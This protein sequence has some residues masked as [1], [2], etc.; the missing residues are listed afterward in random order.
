[1][2]PVDM[3]ANLDSGATRHCRCWKISRKDG[4]VF[5]FTDH[6]DA[7]RFEGVVFEASTGMDAGAIQT[8]TGLSVDNA[9]VVGALNAAAIKDEDVLSGRFDGAEIYQWLVDWSHPELRVL[10]FRGTLGEFRRTDGA[11]EVELRGMAEEL[12]KPVGRSILKTCD[13]RLGDA[14]CGFDMSLP[15]FSAESEVFELGDG[16]GFTATDLSGY[17]PGWFSNG[18]ITWLSGAN[19]GTTQSIKADKLIGDE[20]RVI[21][22]WRMPGSPMRVGDRFRIVAGCDKTA[23]TCAAKFSNLLNFRGFPHLPYEDWVAAYP[24]DGAL[25]DGSSLRNG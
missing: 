14:K 5:G 23:D 2:I 22:L 15:G 6:D 12:N 16:A 4:M 17:E 18:T 24:K 3:Q 9:Q 25:H 13:R 21:E 8:S 1:M 10:M 7:M 19:E 20:D 11:F